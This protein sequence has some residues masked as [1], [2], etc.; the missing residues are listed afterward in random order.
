MGPK[1]KLDRLTNPIRREG[2]IIITNQCIVSCR[3]V[4]V[5]YPYRTSYIVSCRIASVSYPYR[6][7][8]VSYRLTSHCVVLCRIVSSS[9]SY[10][11]VIAIVPYRIVPCRYR[12]VFVSY[13]YRF[14]NHCFASYRSVAYRDAS[15]R[16]VSCC[17]VSLPLSH[18][19]RIV[20]V[21]SHEA[22]YRIVSYRIVS[23][24]IVS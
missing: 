22:L 7:C 11:I 4:S 16:I 3:I 15:Y 18:R 10:H 5:P 23:Y 13:P 9:P 20:S 24:R 8:I 21:S 12:I 6:I 2:A 19:I 17:I 1:Q 14:T